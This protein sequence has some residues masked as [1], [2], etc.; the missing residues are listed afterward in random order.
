MDPRELLWLVP[1]LPLAGF[2]CLVLLWPLADG[3]STRLRG[4]R[5]LSP[6]LAAWLAT[7]L[8]GAAFGLSVLIGLAQLRAAPQAGASGTDH[9]AERETSSGHGAGEAATADHA[10]EAPAPFVQ[11][12]WTWMEVGRDQ[13]EVTAARVDLPRMEEVP[14]GAVG[15]TWIPLDTLRAL[16]PDAEAELA[17]AQGRFW[18]PELTEGLRPLAADIPAGGLVTVD[19]LPSDG[20]VDP[21]QAVVPEPRTRQRF[22]VDLALRLDGLSLLMLLVVTGVGFLIHLYSIGYMG[23]DPGLRRYFSYLNLFVFSMLMLVLGANFLVLFVGWE[24]VGAC[25]YL[26]IGFWHQDPANAAAGRKAFVVN[27]IGDFAF[28]I[29]LMLVW[30]IFGSLDYET[31]FAQ[32]PALL[33]LGSALATAIPLLLLAGAT[34]KSAQIPLYVWLPDAMA[35]PTPVSA[36]IHA[37]TM[38]TAGVY[39]SARAHALFERAPLVLTVMA[40]V[41]C[42]TA[43]VA[44]L[45]ATVQVDIK[46]VLAY[47]TV[48]QL[49]FMFMGVGAGA[50]LAG[51]FHLMTHAFFKALLFLGAGSLMHAMEHGFH[52]AHQHPAPQDGVPAHQDLRRM[53][54]LLKRAPLTGWTFLVGGLALAGFPGLA[55]FWSKDEIVHALHQRGAAEP[56]FLVLWGM[57]LCTAFLTAFYTGRQL[58]LALFGAPRS[59][60][61]AQAAESPWVMTVPLLVLAVLSVIGWLPGNPLAGHNFLGSQVLPFTGGA[62]GGLD[63]AGAATATVIA[64]AG[65]GLAVL[66]FGPRPRLNPERWAARLAGPRRLAWNRFYVDEIYDRLFVGPFKRLADFL[67]QLVDR[68]MLDGLVNWIGRL[69]LGAGQGLRAW[70]SGQLRGYAFS[71]LLGALLLAWYLFSAV[72]KG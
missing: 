26:L 72:W 41:G 1:A 66:A 21:S 37:A 25:S 19:R 50:A 44:A 51:V 32:A 35:G 54:G 11:R 47:S 70:Q 45:I 2:L 13:V 22:A 24:L 8:V 5:N 28:I 71:M 64:L 62:H 20:R 14:A 55:G 34:G 9:G 43:L 59:E 69:A 30:S 12:L 49:G 23:H 46:R 42:L 7:A 3:L 61:A 63:A 16:N 33:P 31:V 29:A 68:A 17:A 36:L 52:H 15:Q 18:R 39:M 60:G 67:W 40:V 65:L 58:C 4:G 38:V 10:S 57:A 6:L 56:L 48:S 53:G 27:R